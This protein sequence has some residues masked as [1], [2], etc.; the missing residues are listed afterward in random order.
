MDPDHP[1]NER[2]SPKVL[3]QGVAD[4]ILF[5]IDLLRLK[6]AQGQGRRSDEPESPAYVMP[7]AKHIPPEVTN[8]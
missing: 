7:E 2:T 3:M 4:K 8:L 6:A 1:D 5:L